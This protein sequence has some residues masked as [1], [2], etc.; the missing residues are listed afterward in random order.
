MI[1][2]NFI[3]K[4]NIVF[5]ILL[6]LQSLFFSY[7]ST[8]LM[9]NQ[10]FKFLFYCSIT[11]L[12][13]ACGK[14][15]STMHLQ[16][17]ELLLRNNKLKITD[18]GKIDK[19]ELALYIRQKPNNL[20]KLQWKNLWFKPDGE[21]DIPGV[22]LDTLQLERSGQ[23][24]LLYLNQQGFYAASVKTSH[25]K[26][27]GK[28]SKKAKT[29]YLVTL[30][31]QTKIDSMVLD[32]QDPSILRRFNLYPSP[33]MLKKGAVFSNENLQTERDRISDLMREAGYFD[34]SDIYITYKADTNNRNGNVALVLQV[35]NPKN[36]ARHPRY[37][38]RNIYVHADYNEV[39]GAA[40]DTILFD[41]NFYFIQNQKDKIDLDVVKHAIFF[42]SGRLYD[43]K[44]HNKT[45]RSL[46]NLMM[47]SNI[48]I[49]Y[50][51]HLTDSNWQHL[52]VFVYLTHSKVNTLSLEGTAT[53]REG[54][55]GNGGISFQRKNALGIADVIE[56]NISGGVENLKS[57]V[58]NE[59]ILGA[60]FGPQFK[61]RVPGLMF[62]PKLSDKLG[63][64]SFPKSG[65]SARYN[66]QRR[67]DYTRH[68]S[69]VSLDYEW[70]ETLTKKHELSPFDLSFSFI[71]KGSLILEKL[72]S[73][74]ISKRYR[75]DN[76]IISGLKYRYIFNNQNQPRV[77]NP[78]YLIGRLN[79]MGPSA[80][81]LK[82][83][84][85]MDRDENNALVINGIRYANF[86][87]LDFDI[88]KYLMFRGMRSIA[89]RSFIGAGIPFDKY[90]VIPF[91]QLYFVGGA[92]SI[93]GWQQRTLGPGALNN[94]DNSVDRLGDIRIELNVEYRFAFTKIF[95]SALFVDAGNIWNINNEQ[96]ETNFYFNTFMHQ[97]AVAT[98][99]G[100]RLDFDFFLFRFDLGYPIKQAY[101]KNIWNFYWNQPNFNIG[102]GY[103]F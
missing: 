6:F 65:I 36:E 69:N 49:D 2:S 78:T 82:E 61:L 58:E 41:K 102:I 37:L 21:K 3:E 72:E 66:Y 19:D 27:W 32:I 86:A 98:G 9:I 79:I 75:F 77:K 54:F 101:N 31:N 34:F 23:Q 73:F 85:F 84:N 60:N 40:K 51:K 48:K 88:R 92:N 81:I 99:V 55:G 1:L 20:I 47:Y 12:F 11:L 28:N 50:E 4:E 52:D 70:N 13:G 63:Q 90:S 43:Y 87:R 18:K 26:K 44:D 93:R 91:D 14:G 56:F 62:A 80:I 39:N 97:M 64:Q 24:M 15:L 74:S 42:E 83:L 45:F 38:L 30:G 71:E 5:V 95:K 96:L 53:F 94:P 22:V 89:M 46:S 7:I 10:V 16:E 59:R 68:L 67:V 103:P 57:T 100:I 76:H 29:L 17:N 35:K 33:Y 8:Y 25:K